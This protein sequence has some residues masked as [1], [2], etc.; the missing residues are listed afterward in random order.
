MPNHHS[1][2]W[3]R[4]ECVYLH[5]LLTTN[6]ESDVFVVNVVLVIIITEININQISDI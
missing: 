5:Y 1:L 6:D 2:E 4:Y 3:Y